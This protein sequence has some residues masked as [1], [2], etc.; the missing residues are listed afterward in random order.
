M[1]SSCQ[2]QIRGVWLRHSHQPSNLASDNIPFQWGDAS[3]GTREVLCRKKPD[4]ESLN[5]IMA[6]VVAT[7]VCAYDSC[8]INL[9]ILVIGYSRGCYDG[10][11]RKFSSS[12]FLDFTR[13]DLDFGDFETRGLGW[14]RRWTTG[15]RMCPKLIFNHIVSSR[16]WISNVNTGLKAKQLPKAVNRFLYCSNRS[17]TSLVAFKLMIILFLWHANLFCLPTPIQFPNDGSPGHPGSHRAPWQLVRRNSPRPRRSN[18]IVVGSG[19]FILRCYLV[20]FCT[21]FASFKLCYISRVSCHF[22]WLVIIYNIFPEY[23]Q[24]PWYT[25]TAV[26]LPTATPGMRNHDFLQVIT[27]IT[28]DTI[29][30]ILVAMAGESWFMLKK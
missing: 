2:R 4:M 14:S 23:A 28:F 5:V 21:V 29:H 15:I 7:E 26:S 27:L 3:E 18:F 6:E 9:Q 25:K 30:L 22:L 20:R 17:P 1:K 13:S 12:L 19:P 10:L 16:S 11:Q 24:D 8:W